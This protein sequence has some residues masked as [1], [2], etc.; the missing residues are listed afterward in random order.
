MRYSVYI[1]TSIDGF[2]ATSDGGLQWLEGHENPSGTDYG[3]AEFMKRIDAI[4]MG[5][6][7]YGRY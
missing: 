5:R 2:I 4:V 6:A 1:A 3:Y 7:T